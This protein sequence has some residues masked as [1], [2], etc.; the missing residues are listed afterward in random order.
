M[1]KRTGSW[2]VY[3]DWLLLA[4]LVACTSLIHRGDEGRRPPSGRVETAVIK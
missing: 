4:A 3:L 2:K 1:K